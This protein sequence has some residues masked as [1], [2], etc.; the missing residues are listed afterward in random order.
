MKTLSFLKPGIFLASVVLAG[1]QG[2]P[3]AP[4][5]APGFTADV[6][7]DIG[8]GH[9]ADS[10]RWAP[11]S[12]VFAPDLSNA[13]FKPGSWAWEDGVLVSKGGGDI[14]TKE[15]YGDFVLNLDFRCQEKTNSGVFLRCSN[16]QEWLNTA[17]EVQILQGDAPDKHLVGAV[18]DCVA[19]TRQIEIIPGTWY[20]YT[21]SAV[22]SHIH[23]VLN[24]EQLVDMNLNQWK[25]AGKNPDGTPNKFKTAYKDMARV[26]RIGLQYHTNKVEF[27]NIVVDRIEVSK[28]G[29]DQA[30]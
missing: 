13:D 7:D 30:P 9:G 10:K 15:S 8:A 12:P 25:E 17:I 20:H 19:P 16:I 4:S 21:I 14:W 27:K 28:S 29:A 26:G 24:G 1:C 3:T 2:T 18:Y 11:P 6:H 22:G 23:V 5:V